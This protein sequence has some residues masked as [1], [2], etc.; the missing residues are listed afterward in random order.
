MN[1]TL[2]A[3]LPQLALV[4][5]PDL[6]GKVHGI[7]QMD[8]HIRIQCD[9]C[10]YIYDGEPGRPA[11]AVIL[12]G[13]RFNARRYHSARDRDRRRLCRECRKTEWGESA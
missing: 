9:G 11:L 7:V 6:P 5:L 13:I 4:L 8:P 12:S 2:P 3:T 10:G 1:E